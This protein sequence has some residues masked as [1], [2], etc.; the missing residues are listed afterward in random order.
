MSPYVAFGLTGPKRRFANVIKDFGM[1]RSSWIICT[2]PKGHCIDPYTREAEGGLTQRRRQ[3]GGGNVATRQGC[4]GVPVSQGTATV[5]RTEQGSSLEST[6]L[7][8]ACLQASETHF[9]LLA[10]RIGRA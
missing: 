10:F 1:R 9:R 6:A 7:L 2:D 5:T 3:I 4:S 8:T